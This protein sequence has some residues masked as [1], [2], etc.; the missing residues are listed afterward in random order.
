PYNS[1]CFIPALCKKQKAYHW[2]IFTPANNQE[3]WPLQWWI[4]AP[5]FSCAGA[6]GIVLPKVEQNDQLIIANWL[7]HEM[8]CRSGIEPQS[9]ELIGLIETGTAFINL[10]KIGRG[11][12]R[13][14]QFGLGI[15]DL[16]SDLSLKIDSDE[17]T[18]SYFRSALVAASKAANIA[19]PIDSVWLNVNDD[20][21]MTSSVKRGRSF[22]LIGKFVLTTHQ[23]QLAQ[24]AI[25]PTQVEIAEAQVMIEA[26]ENAKAQGEAFAI[27]NG[28]FI[29]EPIVQRYREMLT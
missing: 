10:P 22:G 3:I 19:P 4:I 18:I 6:D 7:I 9:L 5:A 27:I 16:I 20:D 1:T 21:G 26:Y 12:S 29:D 28:E 8:E 2:R 13:P 25:Q 23:A 24:E 15:G 14:V 17:T 11:F